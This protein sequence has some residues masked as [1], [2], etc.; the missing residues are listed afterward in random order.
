MRQVSIANTRLPVV[1]FVAALGFALV[2]ARGEAAKEP[3]KRVAVTSFRN[4]AGYVNSS[5]GDLGGGMAEKLNAALIETDKFVVLERLDLAAVLDEQN[6][7]NLAPVN[8]QQTARLTTAQALILGVITNVEEVGEDGAS[9]GL[10]G[11]DVGLDREEA[12]VKINIRIVDTVTGQVITSKTITGSAKK[13]KLKLLSRFPKLKGLRLGGKKET[14]APIGEALDDAVE[15]AVAQVVAG[16]ER[17][18]WQGS[19]ARVSGRQIFV[20]AGVQENVEPGL[21]LR[22]FEKGAS[23]IDVETNIDLGSLDEEIGVIEVEQVAPKFSVARIVQ[24]QGFAPGNIVRPV[25]GP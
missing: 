10:G 16:L 25:G 3:K 1:L 14:K 22:V 7:G 23:L 11:T 2:P 17:I 5:W 9:G 24:G 15:Q 20:N 6:L 8:P 18:P 13:R 19:I 12:T 21:Q 4:E